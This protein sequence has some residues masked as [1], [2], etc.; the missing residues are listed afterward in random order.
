MYIW[1]VCVIYIHHIYIYIYHISNIY[2]YTV[3]IYLYIYMFMLLMLFL[4]M[5]LLFSLLSNSSSCSPGTRLHRQIDGQAPINKP[6]VI[7]SPH[8]QLQVA[9]TSKEKG[10]RQ[11]TNKTIHQS[12]ALIFRHGSGL[13][14]RW[15]SLFFVEICNFPGLPDFNLVY[16]CWQRCHCSVGSAQFTQHTCHDW[17]SSKR[18]VHDSRCTTGKLTHREILRK[19]L[20]SRGCGTWSLI[21]PPHTIH[22]NTYRKASH[23]KTGWLWHC[24]R[25]KVHHQL[26]AILWTCQYMRRTVG[27]GSAT[28]WGG[29]I[30]TRGSRSGHWL[31]SLS[32]CLPTEHWPGWMA[33]L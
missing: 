30:S 24:Q 4:L 3:Y 16:R 9:Q 8:C 33:Q 32:N 26:N 15:T 13:K 17:G 7:A 21:Q 5:M 19:R 2:V 14:L 29:T 1:Y 22:W 31:R 27:A 28:P 20:Q 25:L 23:I 11:L 6:N 18:W 10:P 12:A